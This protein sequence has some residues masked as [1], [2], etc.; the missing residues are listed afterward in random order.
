MFYFSHTLVDLSWR[1]FTA[2]NKC[3]IWKV[4]STFSLRLDTL[5]ANNTHTDLSKLIILLKPFANVFFLNLG[6]KMTKIN[7]Q[8][9]SIHIFNIQNE[10]E[11]GR[12]L[13]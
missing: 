2:I 13:V 12:S 1:P 7:K 11:K 6:A 8:E 9:N 5:E 3:K 4:C 10:S